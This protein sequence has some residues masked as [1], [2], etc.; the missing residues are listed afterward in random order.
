MTISLT[1]ID[2]AVMILVHM[3]MIYGL[4]NVNILLA[5]V[6]RFFKVLFF[7]SKIIIVYFHGWELL[8]GV[9]TILIIKV[10]R[11]CGMF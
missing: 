8:V 9:F 5:I 2:A 10:L 7:Y 4:E 11:K 6:D 3:L 1:V